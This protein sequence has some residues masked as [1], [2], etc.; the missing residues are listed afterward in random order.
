MPDMTTP[1]VDGPDQQPVA[2]LIEEAMKKAPVAWISVAG[3]RPFLVW[4]AWLNDALYVVSGPGEQA[5]PG[6]AD[7]REC[8]VTARG[9][10]GARIV[11][12]PARVSR[13]SPGVD[14]WDQVV[15]ALAGKRLN[16][17]A[18]DDTATRWA[19]EC[20][21]NRLE[22]AGS[23][24]EAG[25]SLPNDSLAAEPPPTPAARRVTAPFHLHRIHRR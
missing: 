21:V 18:S 6:L 9:D 16:L 7:A 11:T 3:G 23:P 13:L 24:I 20:V 12:W 10:N 22:P 15:T 2:A 19:T 17:P 14:P 1:D 4:C 8:T 25:D 5:A